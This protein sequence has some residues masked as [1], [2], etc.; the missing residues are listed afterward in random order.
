MAALVRYHYKVDP[1]ELEV[2]EFARLFNEL[3][4]IRKEEA[5]QQLS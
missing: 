2:E 5:K 4:W 1:Y 3:T